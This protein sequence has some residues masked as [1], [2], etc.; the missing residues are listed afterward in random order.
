MPILKGLRAI[1]LAAITI[2][3]S[4]LGISDQAAAQST[5]CLPGSVKSALSSIQSRFGS[6]SIVS[7]HRSGARIAGTGQ[8]SL[9]A[10]C[11]AAD[12]KVNS[13]NYSRVVAWLE[14]N[15]PG[16]VGTYSCGMHHIHI[17]NGPKMRWHKCVTASGRPVGSS[18]SRVASSRSY[19]GTRS[20]SE[21]VAVFNPFRS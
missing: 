21:Q 2:V 12:F 3:F 9:H 16:G 5:G 8:R 19:R 13:G 11:R 15:F 7:T 18:S 10:D 6:I 4:A 1:A 20:R 14:S 17:D